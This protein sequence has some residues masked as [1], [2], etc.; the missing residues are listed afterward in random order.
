MN[1]M[2]NFLNEN[3]NGIWVLFLILFGFIILAHY[4]SWVF[5][6]G[7]FSGDGA[8]TRQPLNFVFAEAVIKIINDFRHLLALVLVIVFASALAYA[9]YIGHEP[10]DGKTAVENLKESLQ[11][12]MATLGGLVGSIIG[13]YFG[14]SSRVGLNQANSPNPANPQNT[15]NPPIQK[16]P[17][18]ASNNPT[19]TEAPTPPGI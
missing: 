10:S 1:D 19:I 7:R 16:P 18:N 14:E 6:L 3:R 8:R 5:G 13:Y 2:L 12:V 17:D 15:T 9:L 4:L 11:G